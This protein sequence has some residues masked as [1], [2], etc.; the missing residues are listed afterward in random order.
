M[1]NNDNGN[2]KIRIVVVLFLIG[3]LLIIGTFAYSYL[4]GWNYVDSFYFSVASLT[5]AGYGDLC[6]TT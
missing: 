1:D 3:I 6:P 2:E 5:S 4:E